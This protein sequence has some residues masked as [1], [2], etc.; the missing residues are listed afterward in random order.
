ME[1]LK[2]SAE[3]LFEQAYTYPDTDMKERYSMLIGLDEQKNKLKKILG[4][5]VNPTGIEEWAKKTPSFC[6]ENH[7]YCT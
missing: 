2:P 7:P 4:L 3:E 6:K 1:N 5:L